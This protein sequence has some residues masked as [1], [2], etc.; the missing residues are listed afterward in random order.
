LRAIQENF[1]EGYVKVKKK[2]KERKKEK[3]NGRRRPII[4]KRSK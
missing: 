4:S 3:W 1:E 2:K